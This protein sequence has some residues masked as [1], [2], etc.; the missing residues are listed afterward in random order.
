ML[1]GSDANLS[2][3]LKSSW[4]ISMDFLPSPLGSL[5]GSVGIS[6]LWAWCDQLCSSSAGH[7][8][9]CAAGAGDV[10]AMPCATYNLHEAKPTLGL[11]S[12]PVLFLGSFANAA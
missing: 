11:S 2:R 9:P 5:A 12:C 4:V 1:A 8:C 6:D 7:D 10:R 3:A